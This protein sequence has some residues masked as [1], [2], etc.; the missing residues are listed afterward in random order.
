M[1]LTTNLYTIQHISETQKTV[2]ARDSVITS[3]S[4]VSGFNER[5]PEEL[6]KNCS[7]HQKRN[8]VIASFVSTQKILNI[9]SHMSAMGAKRVQ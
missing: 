3:L 1:F 8:R 6:L 9:S 2:Q 4:A 7:V 5:I